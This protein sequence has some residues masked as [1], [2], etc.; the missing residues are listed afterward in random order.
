VPDIWHSAKYS[1]LGK[2]PVSRSDEPSLPPIPQVNFDQVDD[3]IILVLENESFR[4]AVDHPL[5]K[6][7][8]RKNRSTDRKVPGI[9]VPNR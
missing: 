1:T 5:M 9:E 4:A 7:G 3:T 8:W 2:L 6:M